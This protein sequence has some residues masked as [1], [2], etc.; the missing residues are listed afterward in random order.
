MSPVIAFLE[1]HLL[2]MMESAIA[3][4]EPELQADF[5]NELKVV[6]QKAHDWIESKI[7]SHNKPA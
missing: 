2:G 7:A 3:A 4:H 6:A 1:E 5:L